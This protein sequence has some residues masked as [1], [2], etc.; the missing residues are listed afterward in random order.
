VYCITFYSFKGGVGRSLALVNVGAQLAQRGRKVLLVDFDLEAPGLDTFGLL[1]APRPHPQGHPGMV[2]YVTEYMRTKCVPDIGDFT[3]SAGQIGDKDGRL[4]VMP[5]GRRNHGD[6]QSALAKIDWQALYRHD[7]GFL[8]FEDT[9]A[10]W[11]EVLKPDYVLIDSRTGHTDVEGICTRQLP[12]AVAVLFFPNE[13]NLVGLKDVSRRIRGEAASG[14]KKLIELH[15]VASNVPDLDDDDQVINQRLKVFREELRF[16]GLDAL[17][18]HYDSALLFDQ[19]VFVLEKPQTRLAKEY[20]KLAEVLIRKNKADR[21]VALAQLHEYSQLYVPEIARD[22]SGKKDDLHLQWLRLTRDEWISEIS[23]RFWEDPSVMAKVAECRMLEGSFGSALRDFNWV[24]SRV[25]DSA[26]V[27]LQRALC[28]NRLGKTSEATADLMRCLQ[29]PGIHPMDV[30]RCLRELIAISPK[31]IPE[32]IKLPSVNDLNL[33]GKYKVAEILGTETNGLEHA[34][35]YL[36]GVVAD[37]DSNTGTNCGLYGLLSHYLIL[38]RRWQEAGTFIEKAI[39]TAEDYSDVDVQ[40]WLPRLIASWGTLGILNEELCRWWLKYAQCEEGGNY[41]ETPLLNQVNAL[42]S[43]RLGDLLRAQQEIE[44]A[45]KWMERQG[46]DVFSCW[47]YR[48]A[49]P[50]EFLEDCHQIQRL[51]QGESVQPAFLSEP[52]S[53]VQIALAT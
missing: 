12:D 37:L 41:W 26:P 36:F 23:R 42:A 40:L 19:T 49:S 28:W 27:L 45:I 20:C 46:K 1:R 44:T 22:P 38:A 35:E 32:A 33:E 50:S 15:F 4:W 13:Q 47:R 7:D 18:H 21:E 25:G 3:Y 31:T 48:M 30:I 6:Y 5:A 24:V 51:F 29:I 52:A 14:L 39:R 10:Q 2:E 11:K 8:L 43:W 9:K 34:I 17:I 16:A 53:P